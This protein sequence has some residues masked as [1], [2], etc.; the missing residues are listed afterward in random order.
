MRKDKG[1]RKEM[2][3][4]LLLIGIL[5]ISLIGFIFL[6]AALTDDEKIALQNELSELESGLTNN[7]YDWLINYSVNYPTID[8]MRY[9]DSEV[10]ATFVN[11]SGEGLYKIFLTNLSSEQ[12]YSQ[13]VFELWIPSEVMQ[14]KIRFD[15]IRKEL[16][17]G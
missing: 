1:A 9:N 11:I 17:N 16:K 10:I 4:N 6:A 3:K 5:L 8:V 12:D 7:G 13:D 2:S 15:E 14:K